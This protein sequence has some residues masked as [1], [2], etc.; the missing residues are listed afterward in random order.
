MRTLIVL[1][2]LCLPVIALFIQ[3]C[4]QLD[5]VGS[6]DDIEIEA[7]Y[8][9][10]LINST[11]SIHDLL[12]TSRTD[13]TLLTTTDDGTLA[14]QYD[15]SGPEVAA[16]DLFS[17]IPDF[18]FVIPAE[19]STIT[20][21]IFPGVRLEILRLNE[22]T[23]DFEM[24][25]QF[26][27]DVDVE[28][29]FY[30]LTK[31]DQPL[32]VNTRIVYNGGTRT[33]HRV[34]GIDITGYSLALIDQEMSVEYIATTVITGQR[35]TLEGVGGEGRNWTYDYVQG[36]FDRNEFEMES[37]TLT[38]DLFDL[39]FEGSLRLADPKLDLVFENSFG[40][41]IQARIKHLEM[42]NAEGESVVLSGAIVENGF[43]LDSPALNEAGQSK[44]STLSLNKDNSNLVD[45][46]AI[47]P[48]KI[49]YQLSSTINPTNRD[50]SGFITSA[51]KI[52]T[53]IHALIPAH[54]SFELR[55][56]QETAVDFGQPEALVAAEFNLITTNEMPVGATLQ[57]YFVD[58]NNTIIDSL[59]TTQELI[60][61]AAPVAADGFPTA[62]TPLTTKINIPSDRINIL[63]RSEKMLMS[64]YLATT[65]DGQTPVKITSEQKLGVKLG[66]ILSIEE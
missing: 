61:E 40:V 31:N 7:T 44:T 9:L 29:V 35:V 65:D 32:R 51:S 12:E 27:E 2:L 5:S 45:L 46:L 23:M 63:N 1:R 53:D 66:A 17:D 21:D 50:Q 25:S 26:L 22:G 24:Y 4:T 54:G 41:S 18:P 58:E 64:L 34:S 20:V 8:A 56:Q 60:L 39:G 57:F 10:P 47:K 33:E 37:D 13:A 6:I 28:I 48:Q 55:T 30:Q 42:V 52:N 43:L 3:S 59:F 62:P 15:A 19:R 49:I 11:T 36:G 16:A 14:F 38:L